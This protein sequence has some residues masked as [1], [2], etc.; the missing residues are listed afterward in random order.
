MPRM[1]ARERKFIYRCPAV[2]SELKVDVQWLGSGVYTIHT[3]HRYIYT[4]TTHLRKN[5][6]YHLTDNF[7]MYL[8]IKI[9][10]M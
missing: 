1:L 9:Y 3:E 5:F 4:Y 6:F 2:E 7:N 8:E 10:S